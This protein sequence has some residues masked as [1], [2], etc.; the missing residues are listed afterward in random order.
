[1]DGLI[2]PFI[3]L[4]NRDNSLG[5]VIAIALFVGFSESLVSLGAFILVHRS[6]VV[7]GGISTPTDFGLIAYLSV[8]LSAP[9]VFVKACT[10]AALLW[11]G[12]VFVG[13]NTK[14]QDLLCLGLLGQAIMVIRGSANLIA[15]ALTSPPSIGVEHF[16]VLSIFLGGH[17]VPAL[18]SLLNPFSLWYII[19]LLVGMAALLGER[20]DW[21]SFLSLCPYLIAV[22]V[23]TWASSQAVVITGTK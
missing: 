15:G 13:K 19:V 8:L 18:P 22:T 3:A 2:S 1:M 16:A 23:V 6:L 5:T 14:Y 7:Q 10:V 11:M 21:R 20:L 9:A 12:S 4:R 17:I